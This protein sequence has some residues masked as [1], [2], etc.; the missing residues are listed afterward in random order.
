[1]PEGEITEETLSIAKSLGFTYSSSL[2]DDDVPYIRQPAGIVELPVHWELFDLP[3][4]CLPLI[5]LS[6]LGRPEA[7]VWMMC[8]QTGRLSWK[9]QKMGTLF[10]LQ[11][12][13]QA[14]GEQGR[15]FMLEELIEEM[16]KK[17]DIWIATGR[18][19]A[20]YYAGQK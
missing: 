17:D 7:P 4:L 9:A 11:L 13:P 10:N 15:V 1:M 20:S 18:E 16:K 5:R 19:I 12:D 14:T 2:S 3:Y 8:W 6:R